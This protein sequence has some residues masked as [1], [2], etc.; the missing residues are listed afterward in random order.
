MNPES[1]SRLRAELLDIKEVQAP[2]DATL[3][4]VLKQPFTPLLGWLA[5]VPGFI[6]SPSAI[7]KWGNKDYGDHPVGTGPFEFVEQVK[8]DHLTLRRFKDYCRAAC[9]TW[10]ELVFKPIP[11]PLP[12]WPDFAPARSRLPT[13]FH[14]GAGWAARQ[15]RLQAQRM[16]AR[17]GRWCGSTSAKRRS[18][19]GGAAGDDDG[20]R[21]RLHRQGVYFGNATRLTVDLTHLQGGVRTV[22]QRVWS[23]A[24]L[25]RKPATAAQAA[26]RTV[27]A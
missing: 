11:N 3:K 2:D 10:D 27:S 6:S 12:S 9:P 25:S 1:G 20:N 19:T 16:R 4:I 8:G 24:R 26:S 13:K 23:Q 15:P 18:T 22:Y 14:P 21:S 17:A 5:E 7:Q